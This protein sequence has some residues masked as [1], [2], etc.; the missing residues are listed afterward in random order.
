M[1]ENFR[2][3]PEII[4]FVNRQF[5]QIWQSGAAS[6]RPL[7]ASARYAPRSA[8]SVE[9]MVGVDMGFANPEY[10]ATALAA[11]IGAVV[12][13]GELHITDTENPRF[14]DAIKFGD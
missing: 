11:R 7:V 9:I 4:R 10:E 8:A 1:A 6:F 14:G 3:R 12:R 2:S 5:D 13:G